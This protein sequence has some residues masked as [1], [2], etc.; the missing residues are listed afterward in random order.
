[1]KKILII[2]LV[3][4]FLIYV[5]PIVFTRRFKLETANSNNIEEKK[6]IE[7]NYD[8]KDYQNIKLLHT[9]NGEV[10]E[11]DL[12]T[13][14]YGVVAA[15][16]PASFE[17]EALKAQAVVARTY[18]IYKIIK[19][20]KHENADICDSSL[21]CQAWISKEDRLAKWDEDKQEEYLAKIKNCVDETQGK[22]ITYNGEPINAFFHANS[23]GKTEIPFNVWGGSGYDYLQV[24]ETSGEDEYTQYN[25]EAEF[26]KTEF[27]KIMKERD[28]S[29]SINFD[30]ENSIK[31]LER[32]E[33]DRVKEIQIGNEKI[34]GVEAR[35]L[36]SLRSANF[37]IEK[38]K[39]TVKFIVYGYGHGVG[40]SQTGSDSLAKQGKNF[41]DIIHH[42]YTNVEI[43][44]Y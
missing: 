9:E 13:Y 37:E 15:E 31:I 12:D 35:K 5:I 1:M 8:Y 25:S 11:I 43:I 21:C 26:S 24:V 14:I 20:S 2:F 34:S 33:G 19:D 22:I 23:G 36:F 27:E 3:I 17:M 44:N 42:F 38:N 40:L 32:T 6:E 39:D 28:S 41:E 10:E 16:M 30:D 4:I 7:N 29:F 18:T